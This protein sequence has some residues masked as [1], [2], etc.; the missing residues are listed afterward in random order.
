MLNGM[1]ITITANTVVDEKVIATHGAMITPE[2]GDISMY[3]RH[4]DK[5]ACKEHRSIVRADSADFEDFA[6]SVQEKLK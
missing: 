5:E 6:Y 1:K 2:D 3:T 4:L